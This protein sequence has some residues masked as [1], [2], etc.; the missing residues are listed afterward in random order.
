VA[1]RLASQFF[2][3]TEKFFLILM[4]SNFLNFIFKF[5]LAGFWE[6]DKTGFLVFAKNARLA[7]GF[8]NPT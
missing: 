5:Q 8:V 4:F 1:H 3:F 6:T 7:N 2:Q